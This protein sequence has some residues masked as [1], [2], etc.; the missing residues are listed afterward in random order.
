MRRQI[1]KKAFFALVM[2][3]IVLG[4]FV[5]MAHAQTVVANINVGDDSRGVAYDSSRG[6]VF[7]SCLGAACLA[8]T[9]YVIRDSDNTV[10][11]HVA[12]GTAPYGAAYDSAKGEVFVANSGS[13]TLSVIS[14]STNMVVA[15][16]T[17]GHKPYG[18]AD[19]SGR[20]EIFVSNWQPG[21][22]SFISDTTNIVMATVS[23]GESPWDV[24]YDSGKGEV[25]VPTGTVGT[26]SV[27]SDAA[28]AAT[29]TSSTVPE[30]PGIMAVGTVLLV[31]LALSLVLSR[32]PGRKP[33]P[34][35]TSAWF[36][37]WSGS[38]LFKHVRSSFVS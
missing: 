22:V 28:A 23:V 2:L 38:A 6:E 36:F 19:D 26:V 29:T 35:N 8:S 20:G 21:T 9:I 14:D 25:F 18:V 1:G 34:T 37:Y 12:V 32:R 15:T 24:A 13:N 5:P 31:T 4:Y 16:V 27:I 11:A 7:V 3:S 33:K 10:M 30:F 17:V